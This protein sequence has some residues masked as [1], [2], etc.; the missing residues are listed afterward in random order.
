MNLVARLSVRGIIV[1]VND[2][3]DD[4][5]VVA[6]H[7]KSNPP[8]VIELSLFDAEALRGELDH[9]CKRLREMGK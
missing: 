1:D 9:I 3:D 5:R 2:V 8:I 6:I 7:L 4:E